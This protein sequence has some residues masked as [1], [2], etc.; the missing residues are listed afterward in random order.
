MPDDDNITPAPIEATCTADVAP[1]PRKPGTGFFRPRTAE[2]KA[3]ADA[4]FL[5]DADDLNAWAEL[6]RAAARRR[7]EP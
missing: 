7:G 3:A 5:R 1:K 4:K 6:L 2:E